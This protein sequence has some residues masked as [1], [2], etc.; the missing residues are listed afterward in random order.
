MTGRTL[1]SASALT[2]RTSAHEMAPVMG[3]TQLGG[4]VPLSRSLAD[5]C[6]PPLS[7][8]HCHRHSSEQGTQTSGKGNPPVQVPEVSVA[9]SSATQREGL[10]ANRCC[11]SPGCRPC[12]RTNRARGRGA[13]TVPGWGMSGLAM[14]GAS[15]PIGRACGSKVSRRLGACGSRCERSQPFSLLEAYGQGIRAMLPGILSLARRPS[16]IHSSAPTASQI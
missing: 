6:A 11:L 3:G 12:G 14:T 2:Q 16:S 13:V 9:R 10:S 15:V 7:L 8:R 1:T 5:P 4:E